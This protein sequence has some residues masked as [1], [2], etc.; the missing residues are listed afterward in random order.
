MCEINQKC[1]QCLVAENQSKEQAGIF[2]CEICQAN[3]QYGSK[4]N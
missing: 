3:F 1:S 4:V 2:T